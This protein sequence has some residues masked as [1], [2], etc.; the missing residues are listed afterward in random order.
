MGGLAGVISGSLVAFLA[1]PDFVATLAMMGI[2]RGAGL[3][4]TGGYTIRSDHPA[5]QTIYVEQAGP[6]RVAVVLVLVLAIVTH[7]LL[8]HTSLGRSFY[9][10][11]GSRH[12]ARLAGISVQRVKVASY[13]LCG[14]LAAV[15][16]LIA[17]S[18]L[19]SGSPSIGVGWELQAVAI[20]IL[21]GANLMGGEGTVLGTV[22]AAILVGMIDN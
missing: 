1:I 6:V 10:V 17:A 13:V 3:V 20:V 5:L 19:G 8:A 11:G 21:G 7:I 22:L 4:M 18:R 2:A 9:A 14:L 12:A 15:G 16:G